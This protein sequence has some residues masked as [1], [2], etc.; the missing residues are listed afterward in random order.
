KEKPAM[1]PN[2]TGKFESSFVLVDI[3]ENNS[4]MFRTLGNTQLGVWIA[5]GEGRFKFPYEESKYH[6]VAK[7]TYSQYPG[8]PNGSDYNA[9][10]L[11][12]SDGRHMAMMP[13]MERSVFPW[14]WPYYPIERK[15]DELSPWIEAFVNARKWVKKSLR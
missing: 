2:E 7:Y 4:V 6:I 11:V 3:P 9:A 15:D 13:H 12:S 1:M 8:N 5:H 10:A 14:Q